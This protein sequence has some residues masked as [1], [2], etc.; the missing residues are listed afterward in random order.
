MQGLAINFDR[1]ILRVFIYGYIFT[2]L[3]LREDLENF[4]AKNAH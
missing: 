4:R 3:P 1:F 2:V